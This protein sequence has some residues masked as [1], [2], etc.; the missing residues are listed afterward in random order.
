MECHVQIVRGSHAEKA[1]I[2]ARGFG[3]SAEV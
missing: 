1:R 2:V 3:Q